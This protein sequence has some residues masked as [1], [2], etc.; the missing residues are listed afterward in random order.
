MKLP[1]RL[2]RRPKKPFHSAIATSFAVEFAAVEEIMLPQFMASGASNLLLITDERM[3]ALALTDGFEL[4]LALGREYELCSPP[5]ANGVFHPKIVLQI[6]RE[7]GRA[8]VSSANAT[9]AG[10]SG[11]AEVSIEIACDNEEGSEREILRSIWAY[12][13]SL[14]SN[15]ASPARDALRWAR[16]RAPWIDGPQGDP[17]KELGDGS[18]IGFL[19]SPADQSLI[20]SFVEPIGGEKVRK[21]I[22]ISPY[23]DTDLAALSDLASR[24]APKHVIVPIDSGQHEFPVDADFAKKIRFV[25]IRWPSQRFTHAKIVVAMT[26]T[27][28]HVLFGSANCTVAALGRAGQPGQNA[29][30]CIYRRLPRNAAIEALQLDRWLKGEELELDELAQSSA[31]P[32]IPLAA[33]EARRPGKFELDQGSL[34]WRPPSKIRSAGTVQLLNQAG[35]TVTEIAIAAFGEAGDLLTAPIDADIQPRLFFARVL[36]GDFVSTTA[37]IAHRQ[38]LR[39][40]RREA[41]SG[42]VARALIQFS[43]GADFDL[44]MHEAFETLVRADFSNNSSGDALAVTR[45]RAKKG[46]EVSAEPVP[47]S[48]DE[49]TQAR[50]GS[51]R[52]TSAGSNSL[53]GTYCDSVRDF[54]NLLAGGSAHAEARDEDNSW[55][56]NEEETG[57]GEDVDDAHDRTATEPEIAAPKPVK[58]DASEYEGYVWEYAET[59]EESGAS[60]GS[61]DVLRL[62]YWILLLLY[63]ARCDEA[64]KGLE[65]SSAPRSW[66]SLIKRTLVG[67]FC[68]RSP[69]VSRLMVAREYTEMPV[70]FME[71]WITAIWALDAVEALVPDNRTNRDFLKYIPK[72]RIL[73]IKLLG[74]T[75]AELHGVVAAEIRAG[76]DR[77]IGARLGLVAKV[78]LAA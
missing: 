25:Q 50:S 53:A 47:L 19:R 70:D 23:W 36:D 6:G 78:P 15:D 9:G 35:T 71:C 44:W 56:D 21:L 48:Y 29:E 74:L 75:E 28:D 13:D 27:H 39:E 58:I 61:A 43:D 4:P 67:F 37:H 2:G 22:V 5:A 12:I 66:P 72:L 52:Q 77:S 33:I 26:A 69:A 18:L 76:L 40:K 11:N 16:E 57:E 30:A 24:L 1:E 8:F 45:S 10:L 42:K 68:G 51:V 63:K 14:V 38:A 54:L 65:C 60:L 3:A 55:L 62:R 20:D 34:F 31:A 73:M 49:F 46:E 59:L 7:N 17:I 64:P 41:A 32:E